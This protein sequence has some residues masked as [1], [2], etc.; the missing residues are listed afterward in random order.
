MTRR[1]NILL[2]TVLFF[3]LVATPTLRAGSRMAF[4]VSM[5]YP[6]THQFHV[7]FRC[8]GLKGELVD[9][10]LPAWMP[11]FYRLMDY[12]KN[13]SNFRASDGAG[14][15]LPWEKTTR[16]TWRVAAGDAREVVLDYDV[17]GNVRFVANCYLDAKRAFVAP[18]ALYMYP[19]GELRRPATITFKMP[20]GWTRIATGLDPVK[21]RPSTF[22]APDFNVLYD[23]PALLG[24]QE[25]Q[26]FDVRGV[27]HR[28]VIEDV[29]ES[30]DRARMTGDLRRLV[31]AATGLMG[32]IPYRHYTFLLMGTGRGGIEHSNSAAC[33]FDG[34]SLTQERGYR[35]WLSYISHEYFHLFNVK[36]IRPIAL[37][38]F[39]YETENLTDMLWVSEG[40]TVYYENIVMVRAGLMTPE[41][42]LEEM[43]SAMTRF[44]NT[45]GHRY[46]SA[47]ESSQDTWGG[48]GFGGDRRTTMSY[49]DN[50]AMLGAMLDLGI[51]AASRNARS[52]DDVMRSLYRT[53]YLGKKRGFTDAEFREECESAAGAPLPE[54]FDYAATS[55]DV[56]YAKS[57]ALAG[58]EVRSAV[59]DAPGAFLGLDTR[60]DGRKLLVT[61]ATAGSPAEA[62]GLAA[63]DQILEVDGLP[64][65]VKVLSDQI[66]G[67]GPG[68]KIKLRYSRN[69]K[70]SEVEATLSKNAKVTYTIVRVPNPD[71]LQAAIFADWLRTSK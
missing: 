7:T 57:F 1:A 16:N 18:P 60:T 55:K 27:P 24:T 32:D 26:G 45:P 22:H 5:P 46:M 8:E 70:A 10:L 29:P 54:V 59:E 30:V 4:T 12:Q 9:F 63:G 38:P 69:G 34:K 36:R 58:L 19:A 51:R 65:S 66:A 15:P 50:G 64:A 71:A 52:L 40:L 20:P 47:A 6:E 37:G 67:K 49:Y 33:A 62:A 2:G 17:L 14:R 23:C 68:D 39:D 11:G 25:V 48:A 53:Y 28:V 35:G 44:E 42:Y 43:Q 41:Q 3:G 13:V 56:D 61:G 31:E 21:G